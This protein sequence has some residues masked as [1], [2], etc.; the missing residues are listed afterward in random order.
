[1]FQFERLSHSLI[2]AY[3]YLIHYPSR[4][5]Q[6]GERERLLPFFAIIG[7]VIGLS[8]YLIVILFR[9][10]L[11]DNGA[12]F[13]GSIVLVSF[14]L[15]LHRMQNIV[16]LLSVLER[17][18]EQHLRFTN[19]PNGVLK[20]YLMPA[21]IFTFMAVK[22]LS[23]GFLINN[24]NAA[25]WVMLVPLLS[26]GA[27]TELLLIDKHNSH[28]KNAYYSFLGMI[29]LSSVVLTADIRG[30]FVSVMVYGLLLFFHRWLEENNHG[31]DNYF[32]WIRA[33]IECIEMLVL[34]A[35]I[36]LLRI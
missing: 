11:G 32:L 13:L 12:P 16:A 30:L 8:N 23:T 29:A 25:H 9:A 6:N 4:S 2:K 19:V 36:F 21:C 31:N 14:W 33:C 18:A 34:L 5:I 20:I 3:S 17:L 28:H 35:G 1:M 24:D 10:C 15:Y 26:I 27:T 7:I 22:L